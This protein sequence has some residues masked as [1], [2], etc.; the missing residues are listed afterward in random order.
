MEVG[1]SLSFELSHFDDVEKTDSDPSCSE[2]T[3]EVIHMNPF[4]K[5]AP[6]NLVD[7]ETNENHNLNGDDQVHSLVSEVTVD[8]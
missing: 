4:V 6:D 8:Y 3:K 5:D 1:P 2:V 7:E